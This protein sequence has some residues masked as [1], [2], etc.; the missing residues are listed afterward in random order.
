[1]TETTERLDSLEIRIAYQDE[2]IETLNKAVTE[3]W[4]RIEALT[5]EIT[6]LTDR[7]REAENRSATSAAPE[8]PPP[9]Y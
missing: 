7:V 8:P 6:R 4:M 3:Q 2:I 9:H 5:R 1:M